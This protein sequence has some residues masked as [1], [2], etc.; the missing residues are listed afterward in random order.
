M[1]IFDFLYFFSDVFY[2]KKSV[3]NGDFIFFEFLIFKKMI[4]TVFLIFFQYFGPKIN[5]RAL[6]EIF[7]FI[8]FLTKTIP[9]TFTPSSN[10]IAIEY[11]I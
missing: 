5:P 3:F 1:R 6:G 10:F 11:Q 7:F 9:D 4:S 8:I 2:A